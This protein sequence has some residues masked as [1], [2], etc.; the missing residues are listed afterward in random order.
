MKLAIRDKVT[1]LEEHMKT[2]PDALVGDAVGALRHFHTD[3]QYVREL[4]AP[5]GSLIVTKIH[6]KAHPV[7]ILAGRCSVWTEDGVRKIQAPYH[8]ITPAG[9]KRV[10]YVHEDTVWVTV[11]ATK[12]KDL[13]K[14]E[15]EVIAKT[16]DDVPVDFIDAEFS[17]QEFVESAKKG[18]L[19][20]H[21]SE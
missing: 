19:L 1:A 13:E 2:M 9:T 4:F 7:F 10:V 11:H 8:M 6:K 15:E 5:A 14:I 3:D 17:I 12:E 16:F 18:E 20:W 21:G